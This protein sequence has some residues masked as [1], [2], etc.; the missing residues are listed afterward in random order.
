MSQHIGDV[1]S[2]GLANPESMGPGREPALGVGSFYGGP[3]RKTCVQLT[4]GSRFVQLDQ[5]AVKELIRYLHCAV[6][7]G[8]RWVCTWCATEK[9]NDD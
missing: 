8:H 5:P 9:P 3:D 6:N 1:A 7:D 2:F 4:V